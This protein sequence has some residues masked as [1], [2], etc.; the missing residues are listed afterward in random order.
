MSFTVP[1]KY[2]DKDWER[3]LGGEG[4]DTC[5]CFTF[6][7]PGRRTLACLASSGLGWRHV[8][9]SLVMAPKQCRTWAEMD[10]V[11]RLFWS[12]DECAMQLHPPRKDW[13][14]YHEGCLH[15]WQ[16]TECEIPQ[17]DKSMVGPT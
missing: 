14:N 10:F 15:L 11:K 6:T 3:K 17:P 4:D 12:D 16:P 2:R 1:E 7:G 5:G 9:V 8:S 13:V